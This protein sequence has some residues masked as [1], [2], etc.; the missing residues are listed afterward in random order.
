[1]SGGH[2]DC[3]YSYNDLF[4]FASIIRKERNP[5]LADLVEDVSRLLHDYDWYKAGD[6]TRESWNKSWKSFQKKWLKSDLND[7]VKQTIMN[8]VDHM[9]D[10]CLGLKDEDDEDDE[11][12]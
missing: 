8:E 2:F 5:I 7:M 4:D 6:T 9:L 1:M 11:Y 10:N 3:N 12:C